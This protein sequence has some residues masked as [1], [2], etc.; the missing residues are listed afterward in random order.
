MSNIL[1]CHDLPTKPNPE[2]GL[3]LVTGATGY[4]GGRLV[5]ELIA[6]GY[7]VR[8]LVRSGSKYLHKKWP[9]VEIVKGDAYDEEAMVRALEGVTVAYYLIHSLLLGPKKFEI[10]EIDAARNF[11][12]ASEKN[13]VTRI[14]YLG[15]LGDKADSLSPHLKSRL[16]VAEELSNGIIPVTCLRAAIIIGSGSASFEIIKNLVVRLPVVPIPKWAKTLCQPIGIRDVIKY[17]I[18]CLEAK[19]TTAKEYDIGG[20]EILSYESMI[21]ITAKTLGLKRFFPPSPSLNSNLFAYCTSLITPVPAPITIS[22]IHGIKNEVVCI[23]KGIENIIPFERMKFR[24]TVNRAIEK[25]ELDDVET[26]WSDAYP[27]ASDL[28]LK[29]HE[30]KKPAKYSCSYSLAS[31]KNP[32]SLFYSICRIGGKEGWFNNNWMWKTRGMIDR[33]FMGVGSER[34]RRC[35]SKLIENDVI[36]FFRVEKL[37]KFNRLLLRAEMKLPGHAWLEFNITPS[38][39]D[40]NTLSVHAF[41]QHHGILGTLYWYFFL[42]FHYLIFTKLLVAIEKRSRE[43]ER[44]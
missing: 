38:D 34:G 5:P 16:M 28:A 10:H 19:E 31:K 14:I 11:R 41:F 40:E 42:P 13:N 33:I 35:E 6:R 3:I 30:L 24:E 39:N 1:F 12:R 17:L 27:P 23:N 36:D 4:I 20:N 8:V 15:G 18:G 43:T 21:K 25:E 29:L 44:D 32:V 37:E 26:R 2:A 7:S 9:E 22:L